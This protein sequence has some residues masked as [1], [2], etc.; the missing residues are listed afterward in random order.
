MGREDPRK[1]GRNAALASLGFGTF[2][3]IV[4]RPFFFFFFT[5]LTQQ[6]LKVKQ[7]WLWVFSLLLHILIDLTPEVS[8]TPKLLPKRSQ[9]LEDHPETTGLTRIA[10]R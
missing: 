10:V 6:Q 2:F 5:G 8:L 7:G 3:R 9:A 1:P 4:L